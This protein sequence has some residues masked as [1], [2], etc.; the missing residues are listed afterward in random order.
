MTAHPIH[1]TTRKRRLNWRL[2]L[3]LA[4]N[5]AGWVFI[6]TIITVVIAVLHR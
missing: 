5:F 2:L 3:I 6:V 1:F 4:A